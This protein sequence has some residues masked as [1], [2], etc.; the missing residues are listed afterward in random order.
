MAV[1]G[2]HRDYDASALQW[3]RAR[4]VLS[5]EDA[6]KAAG[7]KY[8][9][10]LDSQSDEEYAAYKA[11][12]SF[13]GATARTLAEYLD[14]VFRRAPVV[15]VGERKPLEQFVAD[16]DLWGMDFLR[17]ARQVVGEVLSVGRGGTLVLAG[18]Q[19]RAHVAWFR[20]EDILNWKV[21]RGAG[22]ATLV[23]LTLRD[24]GRLRVLKLVESGC[25]Q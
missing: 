2:T 20:A 11:R 22:V 18:E 6:V 19:G 17:Y 25:V 23:E 4:D 5:G 15:A 9:P 10:R 1:G 7:E 21:Q 16:C 12:A 24:A 3:A 14:L 8:L 13:F